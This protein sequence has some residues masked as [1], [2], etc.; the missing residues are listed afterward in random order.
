MIEFGKFKIDLLVHLGD[1]V[2]PFS[3]ENLIKES[4]TKNII[5]IFGNNDGDKIYLKKIANNF[6]ILLDEQPIILD[7]DNMK[8]LFLH[9]FGTKETTLNIVEALSKSKKFNAVV[10]GHVHEARLDYINSV[11]LLNPGEVAGIFNKPSIAVIES[12][13]LNAK[14]INI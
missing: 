9:G 13:S 2:S 11:L 8:F 4:P 10:Y 7:I 12:R 14:I 5:G 3:L 1:Y 6:N